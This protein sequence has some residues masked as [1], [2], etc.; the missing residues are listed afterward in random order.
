MM[1]N[2]KWNAIRM[3]VLLA[4]SPISAL[5]ATDNT[6]FLSCDVQREFSSPEKKTVSDVDNFM[7]NL[8]LR[9]IYMFNKSKKIYEDKCQKGA[10][11]TAVCEVSPGRFMFE[12]HY[13]SN[14]IKTDGRN[15]F[16]KIDEYYTINRSSGEIAI[17]K[18]SNFDGVIFSFIAGGTCR[19]GRDQ[20]NFNKKF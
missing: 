20:R 18:E 3:L 8:S 9:K 17:F 10:L 16:T 13:E 2:W 1:K 4:A 5:A 14:Y 6:I 19:V 15:N 12:R 11:N 7:I